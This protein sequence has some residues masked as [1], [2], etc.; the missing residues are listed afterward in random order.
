MIGF[1]ELDVNAITHIKLI[2]VVGTIN[3]AY[4]TYDSQGNIIND[5]YPTEFPSGGFDLDAIGVIHSASESLNDVDNLS[6]RVYPNP[7]TGVFGCKVENKVKYSVQDLSGKVILSGTSEGNMSIDLTD[8]LNGVYY[9]KVES[10][11]S[12]STIKLIKL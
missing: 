7:S 3:P 9:M 8:Y 1:T 10:N 5:P 2:D 6:F 12:N 11:G 4:A